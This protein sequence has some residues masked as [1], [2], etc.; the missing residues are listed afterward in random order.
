MVSTVLSIFPMIWLFIHSCSVFHFS[1]PYVKVVI[2]VELAPAPPHPN[3]HSVHVLLEDSL[4]DRKGR[5]V[6]MTA[7][8][9]E[10]EV[11]NRQIFK[12]SATKNHCY[13]VK[14]KLV[15]SNDAHSENS[16]ELIY[17]HLLSKS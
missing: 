11:T 16:A 8:E 7:Q 4:T 2:K 14:R 13:G 17:K 6:A 10:A 3:T 1:N 15:F 5:N 12:S 9:K